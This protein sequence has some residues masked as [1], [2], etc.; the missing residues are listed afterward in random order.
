MKPTHGRFLYFR[1]QRVAHV[2]MALLNSS[3]F[4]MWFATFSDGFHLSHGLVK[5]F[6]LWAGLCEQEEV[7][8]LALGLEEDIKRHAKMSTRNTRT[9]AIELEEY[10]MSASKGLLDEID[11]VVGRYYGLSEEEMEFVVGYDGK[12][13][14]GKQEGETQR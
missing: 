7:E 11:R 13:R 1:E 2:V 3:L 6:P 12:Y 10:R 5:D 14:M 9:H 8:L 4:Y